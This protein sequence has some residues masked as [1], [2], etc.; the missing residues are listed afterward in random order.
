MIIDKKV[1]IVKNIEKIFIRYKWDG[2][3]LRF[4][5]T[6]FGISVSVSLNSMAV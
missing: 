1:V 5:N 4:I 6:F 2:M 3:K